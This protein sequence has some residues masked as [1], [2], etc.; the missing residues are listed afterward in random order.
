DGAQR[1]PGEGHRMP[2][3]GFSR[4]L[5]PGYARSRR[6][7]TSSMRRALRRFGELDEE[8]AGRD[9][10]DEGDAPAAMADLRLLVEELHALAAQFVQRRVDVLDLE[11]DVEEALAALGDPFGRDR[12]GRL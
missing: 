12:F 7:I 10:V 4:R 8:V 2:P 5:N 3:P 9:R 11:A 6:P 1:H